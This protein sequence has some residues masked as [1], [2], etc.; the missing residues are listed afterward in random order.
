MELKYISFSCIMRCA[1]NIHLEYYFLTG[2]VVTDVLSHLFK[3]RER[4]KQAP[5]EIARPALCVHACT[6]IC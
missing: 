4:D 2:F 3:G 6:E 5:V 1:E